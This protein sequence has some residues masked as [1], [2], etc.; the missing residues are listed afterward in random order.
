MPRRNSNA[1][2]RPPGPR[3]VPS[4]WQAT[5]DAPSRLPRT[6]AT[7][8][9][10]TATGRPNGASRTPT[11][12]ERVDGTPTRPEQVCV[13]E[14]PRSPNKEVTTPVSNSLPEKDNQ[15]HRLPRIYLP[16]PRLSDRV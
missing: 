8:A 2:R 14:V 10:E 12:W 16:D 13:D 6:H 5:S 4:D 7:D 9:D 15:R 11:E 1:G 3:Q